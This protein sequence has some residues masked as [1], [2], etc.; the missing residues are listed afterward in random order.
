MK[1]K[2]E[3]MCNRASFLAIRGGRVAWLLDSDSHDDIIAAN[4]LKDVG[5]CKRDFIRI[6]CVPRGDPFSLVQSE[7]TVQEDENEDTLPSWY[8]REEWV[9][10]ILDELTLRRI[11]EEK[12]TG[13]CGKLTISDGGFYLFNWLT[14]AADVRADNGSNIDLPALTNAA[15]VRAYDGSI[16]APALTTAANISAYNGSKLDLPALTTA[17]D[18][19]A[20]NGSKLDLPALTT[21]A[22]ISADNGSIS[23]PALKKKGHK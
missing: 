15:D 3:N 18:V 9:S 12:R 17:A 5:L 21:A 16:S 11:P 6:E 7:W 22:N 13:H 2:E 19:I 14:T 10:K 4:G 23:A 20:D 1:Q 8:D